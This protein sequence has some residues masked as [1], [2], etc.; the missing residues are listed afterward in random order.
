MCKASSSCLSTSF[1]FQGL[2]ANFTFLD[3]SLIRIFHL[4]NGKALCVPPLY[5][6]EIFKYFCIGLCLFTCSFLPLCFSA[7]PF[8]SFPFPL[9]PPPV[10]RCHCFQNCIRKLTELKWNNFLGRK[11]K[12]IRVCSLMIPFQ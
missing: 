3:R 12:I 2:P 6:S 1:E 8:V 4:F 10:S 7:L 5:C 11:S 9:S